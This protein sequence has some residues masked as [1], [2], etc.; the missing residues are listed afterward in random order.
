VNLIPTGTD[1]YLPQ[2]IDA[3]ISTLYEILETAH[4]NAMRVMILRKDIHTSIEAEI[5][6]LIQRKIYCVKPFRTLSPIV[7]KSRR[8]TWNYWFEN[9][10]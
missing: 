7:Q 10:V 2:G 6:Q 8:V 3:L 4:V 1:T 9:I 5:W